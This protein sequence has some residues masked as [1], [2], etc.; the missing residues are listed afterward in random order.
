MLKILACIGENFSDSDQ[1]C[2]AVVSV[3][4]G[5]DRIQLWTRDAHDDVACKRIGYAPTLTNATF[6]VYL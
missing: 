3:R 2:G 5:A 4:K 6:D 1:I